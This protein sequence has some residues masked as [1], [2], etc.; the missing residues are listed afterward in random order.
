MKRTITYHSVLA[1]LA[2]LSGLLLAGC[3]KKNILFESEESRLVIRSA[4]DQYRSEDW[5]VRYKAIQ[6]VLALLNASTIDEAVLLDEENLNYQLL[7]L[8]LTNA[9]RDIHQVIRIEALRGL[10]RLRYR[11]SLERIREI[12]FNDRESDNVR[13]HALKT[14]GYYRD[15]RSLGIFVKGLMSDD[16]IVRES[17]VLG[18]LQLEGIVDKDA[19]VPSI[20]QA[21]LDVNEGVRIAVME[22]VKTRDDRIY[23]AL[24]ARFANPRK[25]SIGQ[26]KG[27]LKAMTGYKL[28][29]RTREKVINL[30]GHEQSEVRLLALQV[31]KQEKQGRKP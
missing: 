25:T 21:V 28:D 13:W 15:P 7:A 31:L 19:L 27:I 16:W 8:L 17:A 1:M 11:G 20:V 26:L 2:L 22:N 14:L 23:A 24:S 6:R 9:T 12:A 5:Q 3:V 18:L 29:P 4:Y 10:G 30:L